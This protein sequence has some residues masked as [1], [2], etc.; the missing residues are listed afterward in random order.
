VKERTMAKWLTILLVLLLSPSAFAQLPGDWDGDH[1]LTAVDYQHLELCWTGPVLDTSTVDPTCAS[2]FDPEQDGHISLPDLLGFQRQFGPFTRCTPWPSHRAH[3]Y[4][5]WN[6]P[7]ANIYGVLTQIDTFDLPPLC[8]VPVSSEAFSIR[9]EAIIGPADGSEWS[10]EFGYGRGRNWQG[11]RTDEPDRDVPF[12]FR[13]IRIPNDPEG[14]VKF[15]PTDEEPWRTQFDQQH[16]N[17]RPNATF[18]TD[19]F[20]LADRRVD[21]WINGGI[22]GQP[23]QRDVGSILDGIPFEAGSRA[24]WSFETVNM[25]DSF[26]GGQ[27]TIVSLRDIQ[28][29]PGAHEAWQPVAFLPSDILF[30]PASMRRYASWILRIY[31]LGADAFGVSDLRQLP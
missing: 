30:D 7:D 25:E 12:V 24:E 20:P 17:L 28:F 8:D 27:L 23:L 15:F 10:L 13:E 5:D 16:L 31:Y 3:G 21:F 26:G 22:S 2:V 18:W 19:W 11:L 29:S 9:W 1:V 4:A 14:V 6:Q